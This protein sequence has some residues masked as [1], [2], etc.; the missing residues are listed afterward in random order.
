[1]T[2]DATRANLTHE[3]LKAMLD[4]NPVTGVFT[5]KVRPH[6]RSRQQPGDE[7]GVVKTVRGHQ[8]RYIGIDYTQY[9]ASQLA[10]FYV[11]GA[12]P[13]VSLT[14][15]NE[16]TADTRIENLAEMRTT[17][18]RHDFSSEKGRGN[19]RREYRE[20]NRDVLRGLQFQKYY[21]ITL[22]D[23][24]KM[25]VAQ[26]GVCATCG[27]PETVKIGGKVKWLSVDHNHK[28]GAVRGLLC[29]SCN[30]AIG[31]VFES[32]EILRSIAMYL[33]HHGVASAN[34]VSLVKKDTA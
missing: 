28:T 21:G 23:F 32:P 26:G 2:S 27:K 11:N 5:W 19:Y 16:D 17:P 31:H 4:Y 9:H 24:Q 22:D 8:Y 6:A 14:F 3:H 34:V 20:T 13:G 29:H 18:N 10:W 1:M 25:L 15:V 7:A 30:H 33:E 12:W